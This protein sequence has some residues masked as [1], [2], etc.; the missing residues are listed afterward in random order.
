MLG[1]PFGIAGSLFA[2]LL[3]NNDF[4]CSRMKRVYGAVVLT[5]VLIVACGMLILAG[6][7]S[8]AMTLLI[9]GIVGTVL[10][11]GSVGGQ[12]VYRTLF[13]F[14]SFTAG[15]ATY[16]LWKNFTARKRSHQQC[17]SAGAGPDYACCGVHLSDDRPCAFRG[18]PGRHGTRLFL[19]PVPCDCQLEKRGNRHVELYGSRLSCFRSLCCAASSG[20]VCRGAARSDCRSSLWQ[21]FSRF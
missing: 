19:C 8:T 6:A 4:R 5:V 7:G 12:T 14:P 20:A 13:Y 9:C 16:I 15:V 21:P 2:A 11:L 3:L 18:F 17:S 10:V 1:I